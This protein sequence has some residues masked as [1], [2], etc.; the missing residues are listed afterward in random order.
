MVGLTG[1]GGWESSENT[2]IFPIKQQKIHGESMIFGKK[3]PLHGKHLKLLFS[4]H[5]LKSELNAT[6]NEMSSNEMAISISEAGF[7]F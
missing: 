2:P 1:G 3:T 6:F 5:K 7:K 4:L